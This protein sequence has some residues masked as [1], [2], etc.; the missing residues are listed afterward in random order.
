[1]ILGI[2]ACTRPVSEQ[3]HDL[4]ADGVA[5]LVRQD[6]LAAAAHFEHAAQL[7]PANPATLYNLGN[8]AHHLGDWASA[9]RYYDG[10]LQLD[11]EHAACR[12]SYAL[13][14]LQQGRREEAWQLIGTWLAARPESADAHAEQGW[15]LRESG[16][17]PAA[18]AR[19]ETALQL[20][21]GNV[22]ALIEL[23]TLYEQYAY[24]ERARSLY[25]RALRRDSQQL[26]LLTRLARMKRP[27][28][29]Q[30]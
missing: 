7:D 5:L 8:A 16:D 15:L 21:P 27:A 9:E 13:L 14:L 29:A 30:P 28:P 23:G 22:R 17:L 6:Y 2:G 4:N 24:P 11:S 3:V 20:D 10:C 18:Q 12:H 19:L 1:M 25:E 26:E